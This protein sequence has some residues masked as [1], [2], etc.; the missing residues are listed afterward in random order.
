MS[1]KENKKIEETEVIEKDKQEE[2]KEEIK[3]VK[4]EKFEIK[5]ET[6]EDTIDKKM[7]TVGNWLLA[8]FVVLIIITGILVYYLV[9]NARTD[10]NN[11]YNDLVENSV[12]NAVI[13]DDDGKEPESIASIIDSAISNTL[14]TNTSTS[15]TVNTINASEVKTLNENII[16]LYNGLILDTTKMGIAH[17]QY[18]DKTDVNKDKYVIT[19]YNYENFAFKD[20]ALGTLSDEV[21][22]GVLA[23][24]NVGKIAIS[25]KFNCIPRD[26]QVVNTI[27]SVVMENNNLSKYDTTKTIM[28]DL[29]GNGTNE[30]ILILSNRTKGISKISLVD[31]QGTLVADLAYIEKSNWSGATTEDYYLT[32]NNVEILDI[33]NDGVME[34]ILELPRYEGVPEISLVKYKNGELQGEK[35]YEVSL[36]P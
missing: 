4:D 34:I 32:I 9:H 14:T 29:D 31:Y 30:N 26:V 8:G 6:K 11:M 17:L 7:G 20:S 25:E 22:E 33:D 5:E 23:V 18:I 2:I 1:E 28:V 21:Y 13:E 24:E 27:P 12:I 35:D 3:E 10:L 16:V 36:L 19:Y 15:N